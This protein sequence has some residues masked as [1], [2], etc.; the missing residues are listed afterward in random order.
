MFGLIILLIIVALIGS[1][2]LGA[3]ITE[4]FNSPLNPEDLLDKCTHSMSNEGYNAQT[5]TANSVTLVK[6]KKPNCVIGGALLCMFV[7]PAII[8]AVVGGAKIPLIIT[9]RQTDTGSKVTVSGI[10]I[11]IMKLKKKI[12]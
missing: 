2:Y 10:R 6:D 7:I 1:L 11:L 4:E 9:V 8:Y 3:R 5:R 12:I